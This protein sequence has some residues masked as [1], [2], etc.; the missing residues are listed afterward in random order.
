MIGYRMATTRRAAFF[1]GAEICL[2]VAIVLCSVTLLTGAP[3][4]WRLSFV[5]TAIGVALV[6]FGALHG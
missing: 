3:L 5:T 6:A 4:F 1:D 2:E